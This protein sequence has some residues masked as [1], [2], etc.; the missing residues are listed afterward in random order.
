MALTATER[1]TIRRL[2]GW[3]LAPLDDQGD[4]ERALDAVDQQGAEVLTEV[5][6]RLTKVATIETQ[7]T[8]AL[9]RIKARTVGSI[10]LN[11]MEISQINDEGADE[12]AALYGV[13]NCSVNS[14]YFSPSGA[15][16]NQLPW[17]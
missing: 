11:P 17:G 6:A 4:V 3:A 15:D 12:V 10:A 5:R 8:S 9:T 16:S 2:G 13:L 7:K 14:N 1:A